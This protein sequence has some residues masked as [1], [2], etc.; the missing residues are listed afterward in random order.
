MGEGGGHV[1]NH[2][3]YNERAEILREKGTNRAKFYRGQ[4]DKYTWVDFGDSYLPSEL[5][6]AYLWPQLL[7]ADE[8]T[9]DRLKSWKRYYDGLEELA[10][11]G[12]IELPF[13]PDGCT[14]NAHIFFIKCKNIEERTAL[15]RYLKDNGIMAVFHYIPLHSAPAGQKYGRF[16]GEDRFTTKESERLLRLPM[17]YGLSEKDIDWVIRCI[18]AFYGGRES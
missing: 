13:I 15:I 11:K 18:K 17:Y 10:E 9:D 2:P 14:H 16:H 1:I 6:A 7:K 4:I 8:I 3:S 5:N 12:L